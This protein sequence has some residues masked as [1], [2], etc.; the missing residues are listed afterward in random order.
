MDRAG[1][2]AALAARVRGPLE[3]VPLRRRT[4][5]HPTADTARF[6]A[7]ALLRRYGVVVRKVLERERPLVPW[8]DLLRE[9][10]ALELAGEVRG[11]RFV[12]GFS[13]EQF[14][15]PEALALLRRVRR[16]EPTELVS[17]APT[18]PLRLDGVVTPEP[19]RIPAA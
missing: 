2:E 3:R 6:L 13:G 12:A 18:D 9:L 1:V 10:R 4:A 16:E 17:L 19:P 7:R 11:G 5:A 15:L 8:R 14:A